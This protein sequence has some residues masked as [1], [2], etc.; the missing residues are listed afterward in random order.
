MTSLS[1]II[2]TAALGYFNG[3][4]DGVGHPEAYGQVLTFANCIP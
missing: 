4:I 3:Q 2:S 1:G